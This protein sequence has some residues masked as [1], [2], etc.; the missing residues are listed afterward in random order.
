MTQV[1][2]SDGSVLK[3]YYLKEDALKTMLNKYRSTGVFPN[4]YRPKS[5]YFYFLQALIDMGVNERHHFVDIKSHMQKNMSKLPHKSYDNAWLAFADTK[6]PTIKS[7]DV[8]ARI[9]NIGCTLQRLGG[10]N[11]YGYKIYQ[12]G[13]TLKSHQSSHPIVKNMPDFGLYA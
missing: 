8:N 6:K 2:S 3:G 5:G 4:P 13:G 11:P 10:A 1:L 12:L 7:W 9:K